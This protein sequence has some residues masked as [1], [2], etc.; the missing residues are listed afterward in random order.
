MDLHE[1]KRIVM[2]K[3][4]EFGCLG[5]FILIVIVLCIANGTRRDKA[6]TVSKK[7]EYPIEKSGVMIPDGVIKT[8]SGK[9]LMTVYKIQYEGKEFL[10]F[11]KSGRPVMV[12]PE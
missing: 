10:Y 7:Y 5:L 9:V 2:A 12:Y 3:P 6:D 4:K 11:E 1:I 8:E